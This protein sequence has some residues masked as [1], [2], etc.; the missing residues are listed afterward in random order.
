MFANLLLCLCP[1]LQGPAPQIQTQDPQ[2][3]VSDPVQLSFGLYQSDKATVMYRKF[4][5]MLEAVQDDAGKI[6]GRDVEVELRIFRTY[7]EGIEAL[8]TGKVDFVRFGPASYVLSK[9][10][11]KNIQLLAMEQKKGK[12]RFN[13]LIVAHKDSGIKSL[14]DLAG[15]S[16]AFGDENSTIG[17]Y[18]A[19]EQLVNAGLTAEDFSKYEFLGRHDK[20][21]GAVQHGDFD[22]GSLKEG[23][24]KKMNSDGSLVVVHSFENVTK[25]WIARAGLD[26]DVAAALKQT[27]VR[28]ENP[29]AL[30]AFGV[31]RFVPARDREYNFVRRGMK[32]S[33]RFGSP[34]STAGM[35]TAQQK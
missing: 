28:M 33:K 9:R 2:P 34:T 1:A 23:T 12:T 20:V 32:V 26:A 27:L 7:E 13:G 24:F 4:M 30:A 19:Q 3:E 31:D 6:L 15:K 16:F 21:A 10:S 29:E 17:R 18:L 22:A 35:L 8:A 5:P 25:P 14:A 11:N